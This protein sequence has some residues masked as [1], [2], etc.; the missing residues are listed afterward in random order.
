MEAIA[1]ARFQRFG[2]RKVAQVLKQIRGMSLEKATETLPLTQRRCAVMVA[3]TLKSASSK[4]QK[5]L[6][7]KMDPA[8]I[9]ITQAWVGLGPMGQMKRVKPAPMGRAM[10]FKRKV[11]HVTMV[12]ADER[13]GKR[14]NN[15]K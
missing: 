10:T 4:L 5:K 13:A 14:N 15:G 3:K 12:V 9:W 7:K 6:G 11:C 1:H 2:A 8:N